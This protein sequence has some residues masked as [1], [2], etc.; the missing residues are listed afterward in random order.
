LAAELRGIVAEMVT[1]FT[2]NGAV[3][4]A[5]LRS[6][7]QVLLSAGIHGFVICGSVGEGY[8]LS[9][10]ETAAV[11]SIVVEENRATV[12]ITSGVIASSTRA[13]IR[14]AANLAELGVDGLLVP[15][16][17]AR[18]APGDAGNLNYYREIAQAVSVPIIVDNVVPWNA[19]STASLV[20][21]GDIQGIIGVNQTAG[22]LSALAELL[23]E[24]DGRMKLFSAVDDLI[25]PSLCLGVDG[26]ISSIAT[27]LPD[28]CLELWTAHE[29]GDH[30]R[31][32]DLHQRILPVR[33]VLNQL[34]MPA[35]V[36]AAIELRGRRV[37][38]ARPPLLPVSA[39]VRA[40]IDSALDRAG[41][42]G[43]FT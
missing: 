43:R 18:Y 10:D 33:N 40:E 35:R 1:P 36:K 34:D 14:L 22:G 30:Q 2:R 9:E 25:Y 13:A 8:A 6:E 38:I 21:L 41:V 24:N 16:V 3:D 29:S 4:E 5:G 32:R 7:V 39:P 23:A 20:K 19:L 27:V 37:G 31:A 12:P 26:V 11:T 28:L 17:S 42:L 15:P